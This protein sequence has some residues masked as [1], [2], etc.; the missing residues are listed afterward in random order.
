[1]FH[2][3]STA[4]TLA[5]VKACP[6][7]EFHSVRVLC[8]IQ[9]VISRKAL[10][11]AIHLL[12]V[13]WL[14]FIADP[15]RTAAGIAGARWPYPP[16]A[17]FARELWDRVSVNKGGSSGKIKKKR[18]CRGLQSLIDG[19]IPLEKVLRAADRL[20]KD[21]ESAIYNPDLLEPGTPEEGT[22]EP[23]ESESDLEV[24]VVG[25]RASASSITEAA[26]SSST[27]VVRE[28]SP[29]RNITP[30]PKARPKPRTANLRPVN[31]LLPDGVSAGTGPTRVQVPIEKGVMGYRVPQSHHHHHRPLQVVLG[32]RTLGANQIQAM[33]VRRLAIRVAPLKIRVNQP[34]SVKSN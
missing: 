24:T 14:S 34:T 22:K 15:S 29:R 25:P 19:G 17:D 6:H 21:I 26:S 8:H 1:M 16:E 11:L 13:R 23:E 12:R 2:T 20:G 30:P 28:R 31:I 5:Q 4:N 33:E 10:Q 3:E 9:L 32:I 18:T 7:F 27:A